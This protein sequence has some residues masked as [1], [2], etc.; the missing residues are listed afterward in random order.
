MNRNAALSLSI[1]VL[2]L[3][4]VNPNQARAINPASAPSAESAAEQNEATQ[5]VAAKAVFSK[6]IDARKTQPD[7]QFQ[8][9]LSEKVQ[10]KNG[11]ELPRGTELVGTVVKDDTSEKGTSSLAL[12]FTQARLKNG[13]VVPIRATIITLYDTSDPAG[14]IRTSWTPKMLHVE[15]ESVV[16]GVSMHSEIGGQNSA[17][18][19]AKK[20]D[21]VRLPKG[22]GISL[23]IAPLT[24]SQPRSDAANGGN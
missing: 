12:R 18:L 6:G 16:S 7:Q 20:K 8:A 5:M 9:T 10:L 24:D 23:A 2:S 13:Q 3:A 1:A 14:P 4:F 21:D 15:Q 19:V 17:V 22:Y 11:P